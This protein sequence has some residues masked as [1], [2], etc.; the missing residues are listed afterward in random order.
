MPETTPTGLKL[1]ISGDV[2]E[3]FL[4]IV[5]GYVDLQE[6]SAD[7]QLRML[8]SIITGL[9][10]FLPALKES[11]MQDISFNQDRHS[12]ELEEAKLRLAFIKE[13]KPWPD[14]SH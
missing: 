5:R 4:A 1:E 3:S 14:L 8:D 11:I 12:L 7:A 9:D 2:L 10:A 13:G 6:K